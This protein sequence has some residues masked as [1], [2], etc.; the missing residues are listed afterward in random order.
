MAPETLVQILAGASV[1]M[2]EDRSIPKAV[3]F[4]LIILVQLVVGQGLVV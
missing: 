1:L 3:R 4:G 2:K